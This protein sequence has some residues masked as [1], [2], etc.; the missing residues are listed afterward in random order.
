MLGEL[1]MICMHMMTHIMQ[2]CDV[3]NAYVD[4][5]AD[6]IQKQANVLTNMGEHTTDLIH[7]LDKTTGLFDRCMLCVECW[8]SVSLM[9][10]VEREARVQA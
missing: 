8:S 6:A 2:A 9:L 5:Y 3:C 4:T 10:Q 7:E 1:C